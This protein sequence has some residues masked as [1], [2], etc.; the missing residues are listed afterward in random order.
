[1]R[2]HRDAMVLWTDNVGYN[3]SRPVDPSFMRRMDFVID[4]YELPKER[5][6]DRIRLNT[7]F[8]DDQLLEEMYQ[9][10]EA[11]RKYCK[12]RD[13]TEGDISIVE[14]ERWV[15]LVMI[16]G[17]SAITETCREA[18]VSKAC[19]DPDTLQEIMDGCVAATMASLTTSI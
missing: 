5:A 6:L 4:S 15:Q 1:M 7:G 13:I 11:I 12:D 18:V 17:E 16:E 8:D 14:L 9:V 19:S 10:W 3:S 2:R